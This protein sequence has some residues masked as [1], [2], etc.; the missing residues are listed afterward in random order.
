M[1]IH[2][3]GLLIERERGMEKGMEK[4]KIE[5]IRNGLKKGLSV[6]LLADLVDLPKSEVERLIVDQ[7]LAS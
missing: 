7:R 1:S 4:G 6:N 2:E 3:V 5:V